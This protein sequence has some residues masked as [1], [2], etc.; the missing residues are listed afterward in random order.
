MPG[1]INIAHLKRTHERFKQRNKQIVDVAMRAAGAHA[2]E[3]VRQQSK[4][5]RRSR[6]SLKDDT[7]TQIIRSRGGKILRL[8]WS[9]KHAPFIEYGTRPHVIKPKRRSHLVFYWRKVGKVV[10]AKKVNHPG[11]KPYKFGWK[12]AHAAHRILGQRL[13]RGMTAAA[14]KF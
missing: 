6:S 12:S 14:Q 9:K 10:F 1:P 3:H 5:K 2:V 4:F 13:E 8:K 7:K 11:T